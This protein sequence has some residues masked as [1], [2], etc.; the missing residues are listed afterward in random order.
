MSAT[1]VISRRTIL[2][3]SLAAVATPATAMAT[4]GGLA[5][6]IADYRW[7]RE[8]ELEASAQADA[9]YQAANLPDVAVSYGRRRFCDAETGEVTWGTWVFHHPF[10][11]DR[12]FG[13]LLEFWNSPSRRGAKPHGLDQAYE[14]VMAELRAAEQRRAEAE[15]AAG[16]T[17][18]DAMADQAG[19][20][21]LSLQEAIFAYRPRTMDDVALKNAFILEMLLDK[22]DIRDHLEVIFGAKPQPEADA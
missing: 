20:Q 16:I 12:H 2:T 15:R 7:A 19:D 1:H 5:E 21:V 18:A 9:L 11:V 17:A 13:P 6:L 14:R 10:E 22:R 4:E 8:A 3:G